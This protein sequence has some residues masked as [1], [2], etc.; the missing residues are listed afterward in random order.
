MVIVPL[1]AR[2]QFAGR[3]RRA[4]LHLVLGQL[5]ERVLQGGG[6]RGQLVHPEAV[7]GGQVADLGRAGPHGQ[8]PVVGHRPWRR[9]R[10]AAR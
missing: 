6:H 9:L 8:R 10:Q 7:P 5:H 1:L 2:G 3:R 4:V